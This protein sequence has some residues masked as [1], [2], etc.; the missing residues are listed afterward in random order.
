MNIETL[1]EII[2]DLPDTMEVLVADTDADFSFQPATL[3]KV[4]K[5]VWSE[6]GTKSE[7]FAEEDCLIIQ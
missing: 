4:T 7:P 5:V 3:A 1:K 6:D 2:K